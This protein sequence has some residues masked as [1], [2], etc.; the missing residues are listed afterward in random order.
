MS[1]ISIKMGSTIFPSMVASRHSGCFLGM[2]CCMSSVCDDFVSFV[3]FS[4][5]SSEKFTKNE[6]RKIHRELF[7]Y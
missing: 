3:S 7:Y 2:P 6:E 5:F 1:D 4:L